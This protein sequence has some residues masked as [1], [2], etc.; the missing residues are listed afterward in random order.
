[1]YVLA[2]SVVHENVECLLIWI[3][4]YDPGTGGPAQI[5]AMNRGE[6]EFKNALCTVN[7]V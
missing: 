7:K 6:L 3:I 4:S 5:A 2:H 1:M